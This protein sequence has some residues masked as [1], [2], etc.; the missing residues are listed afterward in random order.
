M[1]PWGSRGLIVL[2]LTAVAVLTASQ[3]GGQQPAKDQ[4][5][6]LTVYKLK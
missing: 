5:V 2:G 1:T 3:I 4:K 6:K